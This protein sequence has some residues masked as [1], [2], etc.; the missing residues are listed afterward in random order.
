MFF[1][2]FISIQFQHFTAVLFTLIFMTENRNCKILL[3]F[4]FLPVIAPCAACNAIAADDAAAKVKHTTNNVALCVHNTIIKD[5]FLLLH[6]LV[7][8]VVLSANDSLDDSES[9]LSGGRIGVKL[10]ISFKFLNKLTIS[11]NY[12]DS[13][14]FD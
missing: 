12:I 3:L 2:I 8:F 11:I 14:R 4:C 13:I 6:V 10:V 7:F 1:E 9:S 5:R